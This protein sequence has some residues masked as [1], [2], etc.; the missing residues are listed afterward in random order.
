MCTAKGRTEEESIRNYEKT[1]IKHIPH[2]NK[3]KWL[4]FP[5]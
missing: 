3:C 5:Y 2:D 1:K 4:K